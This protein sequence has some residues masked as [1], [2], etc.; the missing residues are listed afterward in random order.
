MDLYEAI[1]R[2]HSVRDFDPRPVEP[3]KLE[4]V[5]AAGLAAP[6]NDHLREWEFILVR[7][8][9]ARRAVVEKAEQ[10]K[11]KVSPF[12]LERY[13]GRLEPFAKEMYFDAVPKQ[14]SMLMG[15]PEMLVVAF[16]MKKPLA[17]C[18]RIVD[19]NSFASAWCCV[20]NILLAMAAEGLYGV[21]MVPRH[22]D[23]IR[24]VLGVPPDYEIPVIIPIGYPAENSARALQK[25]VRVA[26]K[27][28]INGW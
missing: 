5:L 10:I 21:T 20:E 28:H 19:L 16:H 3:D 18:E 7:D 14:W 23:A 26:D 25:E 17:K 24:A 9:E 8:L 2:R 6:T 11:K 4:R 22:T 12:I 27:I 1:A 15:A 13:F